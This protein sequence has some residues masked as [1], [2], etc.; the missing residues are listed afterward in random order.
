MRTRTACRGTRAIPGALYRTKMARATLRVMAQHLLAAAE[1]LKLAERPGETIGPQE[2]EPA[3][4][5]WSARELP[6]RAMLHPRLSRQR[7]IYVAL[8]WLSF[9]NRL[10]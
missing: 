10:S 4:T 8:G 9:L 5:R 2:I 6:S 1:Y 3:G 7:F